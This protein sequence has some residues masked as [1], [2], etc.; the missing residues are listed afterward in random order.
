MLQ[1]HFTPGHFS[2]DMYLPSARAFDN[3]S[4]A[5]PSSLPLA[6]RQGEDWD[7]ESGTRT[8]REAPR[9]RLSTRE[10][11]RLRMEVLNGFD[12]VFVRR[13]ADDCLLFWPASSAK[14]KASSTSKP[15]IPT[16]HQ[17][18]VYVHAR[19]PCLFLHPTTHSRS[20]CI[21]ITI[22][23]AKTIIVSKHKTVPRHAQSSFARYP[24]LRMMYHELMWN[25]SSIMQLCCFTFPHHLLSPERATLCESG[26]A[27]RRL[28]QDRRA[29]CTDDNCL[30][31]REDGGDCE[32]TW[33]LYIHEE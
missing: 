1:R 24:E 32:A 29:A 6:L 28:A 7:G 5:K 14:S 20:F 8:W 27:T 11:Q 25:P 16:H 26:L 33:A 17:R 21:S 19:I 12:F 4:S 31:V 10:S 2:M 3:E 22:L 18:D 13:S 30:C 23:F 9:G 15:A